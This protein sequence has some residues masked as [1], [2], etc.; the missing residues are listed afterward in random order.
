M[1]HSC[2]AR[3]DLY[4]IN[5]SV[6]VACS[7]YHWNERF[8]AQNEASRREKILYEICCMPFLHKGN[9]A[10]LAYYSFRLCNLFQDIPPS[11]Q[12]IPYVLS[13]PSSI[14]SFPI[15]CFSWLLILQVSAHSS[16][17]GFFSWNQWL[18]KLNKD[19]MHENTQMSLH[20]IRPNSK[21]FNQ[22]CGV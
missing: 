13:P 17:V 8:R 9:G 15:S 7:N 6:Y 11:H 18:S 20:Y 12:L 2:D 5:A 14:L 1:L 4:I 3:I 10:R 21:R 16:W 19:C 22:K